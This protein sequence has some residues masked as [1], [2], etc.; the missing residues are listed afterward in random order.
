MCA[1]QG[2]TLRRHYRWVLASTAKLRIRVHTLFG[3]RARASQRWMA[4]PCGLCAL[5]GGPGTPTT[6]IWL[7]LCEGMV[8]SEDLLYIGPGCGNGSLRSV[9]VR[10]TRRG[11]A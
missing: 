5:T 6:S 7:S 2:R 4:L 1:L 10:A 9:H 11:A 8:D 3:T